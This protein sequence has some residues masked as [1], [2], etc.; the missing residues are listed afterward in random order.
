MA[1]SAEI[2]LTHSEVSRARRDHDFF[3]AVVAGLE[4]AVGEPRVP[5]SSARSVGFHYAFAAT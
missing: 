5:S 1:S 2:T 3:P 4:E